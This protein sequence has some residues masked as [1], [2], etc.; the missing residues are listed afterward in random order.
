MRPYLEKTLHK[1][2]ARGV[3][4]GE[5]PEFNPSTAKKKKK[6]KKIRRRRETTKGS[7]RHTKLIYSDLEPS[8]TSCE[9]RL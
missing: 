4:Q 8:C 6:K 2:R 1:N 5:C 3:A 7:R 9:S